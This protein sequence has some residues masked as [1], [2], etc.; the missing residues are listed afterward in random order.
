MVGLKRTIGIK[1]A[2]VLSPQPGRGMP[3]RLW[4]KSPQKL[5]TR[6]LRDA[7]RL[8]PISLTPRL[9]TYRET[10]PVFIHFLAASDQ[11]SE[12]DVTVAASFTYAWMPRIAVLDTSH[13]KRATWAL[14]EART[15]SSASPQTVVSVA[16]YLS[17]SLTAASK[18]L[19]FAA[20]SYYAIWDSRVAL[21]LGVTRFDRTLTT[22]VETYMSY[23]T[24]LNEL[25]AYPQA[26][27]LRRILA[28]NGHRSVTLLRGVEMTMFLASSS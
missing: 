14:N 20:P 4:A 1:E 12:R 23:L 5:W 26:A 19:H 17:G 25:L 13:L 24:L 27:R 11:L 21:Y 18:L 3:T 22:G 15:A 7:E 9:A 28:V 16:K 2:A 8:L 6:V 10:Y